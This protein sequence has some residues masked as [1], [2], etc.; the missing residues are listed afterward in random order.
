[1]G[2][3]VGANADEPVGWLDSASEPGRSH[4]GS[5]GARYAMVGAVLG[6][7]GP[8]GALLLRVLSGAE[9]L[10]ELREHS[11]YY[12]YSLLGTCIAFAAAG[13][14]AGRRADRLRLGR[15]RYRQL[16]ELD[17]LTRLANAET[18][19]RH[20]ARSLEH[21]TRL[22]EPLSLMV[23]DIDQLKG[24]NDELGHSFGTAALRHV[25]RVLEECKRAGDIAA[26]WGG[27]EFTLLMPGTEAETAERRAETILERLREEP[28]KVDGRQR[29]VSATIGVAT[30]RGAAADD[31]FEVADRALYAGKRAGRG[32]VRTARA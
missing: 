12:L 29:T 15:D 24:L 1:V 32:T 21:A 18:F 26:R 17:S 19:R 30:S 5:L 16:S 31:L 2:E 22:A 23:I 28:V 20:Y 9:A 7:G 13:F 6:L 25:A 14:L 10:T 27:D 8:A 3:G 11:F 4:G